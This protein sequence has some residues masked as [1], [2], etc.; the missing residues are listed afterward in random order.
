MTEAPGRLYLLD[1]NACIRFL[2]GR[3]PNLRARLQAVRHDQVRV[4]SVVK[5]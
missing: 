3:A 1:S 4:C 2:N 5:A